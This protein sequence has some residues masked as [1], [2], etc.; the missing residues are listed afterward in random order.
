MSK[1][2]NHTATPSRSTLHTIRL[3]NVNAAIKALRAA[4]LSLKLAQQ[5]TNH[6]GST[7]TD[8]ADYAKQIDALLSSDGGECG[9][10][11]LA[12][13]YASR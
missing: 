8:C 11:K 4:S 1:K 3:V 2:Q 6:L 12:V 5:Q 13:L 9:L 7:S 10:E